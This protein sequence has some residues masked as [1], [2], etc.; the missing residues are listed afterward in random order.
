MNAEARIALMTQ[1][2]QA[3]APSHLEIIDESHLHVGHATAPAGGGS[4]FKIVIASPQFVG[5][6]LVQCHR[7]V[8]AALGELVGREIH[9]VRIELKI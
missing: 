6:S 7:L 4:H 9:A 1:R 2:L 8:Y 3:L 5:K